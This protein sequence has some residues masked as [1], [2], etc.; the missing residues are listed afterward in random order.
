MD[1]LLKQHRINRGRK[2]DK[3][4]VNN[5]VAFEILQQIAD[6]PFDLFKIRVK[7]VVNDL[8]NIDILKFVQFM[9]RRIR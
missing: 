5:A 2:N 8:I 6:Y 9:E 3:M 7:S 1:L 4:T